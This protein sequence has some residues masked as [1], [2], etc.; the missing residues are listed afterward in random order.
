[1]VTHQLQDG[2]PLSREWSPTI[3][4][5]VRQHPKYGHPPLKGWSPSFERMVI[6]Q[7]QERMVTHHHKDVHQA[8][9]GWSHYILRIF[10]HHP[11]HGHPL[12]QGWSSTIPSILSI[13]TDNFKDGHP[14]LLMEETF[15]G[16]LFLMK[17]NLQWKIF[18]VRWPL[19]G[20]NRASKLEFDTKD[21]VLFTACFQHT[22]KQPSKKLINSLQT[23]HWSRH[24]TLT[25]S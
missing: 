23:T 14:L 13:L 18:I 2:C 15:D 11:H 17:D 22:Q 19:E 12:F 24:N 7:P 25:T 20:Q 1:M 8:S 16:R 6:H 3:P 21:Q 5:L 4:R 10:M 9:P